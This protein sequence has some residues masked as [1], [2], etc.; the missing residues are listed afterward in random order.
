MCVKETQNISAIFQK[1]KKMWNF[2]LLKKK[3]ENNVKWLVFGR[4]EHKQFANFRLLENICDILTFNE[5]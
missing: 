2:R 4:K 3:K 5:K 1:R